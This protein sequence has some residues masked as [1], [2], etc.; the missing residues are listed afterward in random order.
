[1]LSDRIIEAPSGGY[2][3]LR[4]QVFEVLSTYKQT[5]S[6]SEAG[7]ILVGCYRGDHIEI[8]DASVPFPTDKRSR[9]HFNRHKKGHQEFAEQ[10]WSASDR[11][12]TYVGEWHTHPELVPSPSPQDIASWSKGL[13]N[14]D[15]V[16]LIQGLD[17]LYMEVHSPRR[18]HS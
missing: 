15:M 8:I 14:R 16:L 17:E 11:T 1:M 7:G 5:E 12:M 18:A 2:V 3:L 9:Y 10:A 6:K 13:P 4:A